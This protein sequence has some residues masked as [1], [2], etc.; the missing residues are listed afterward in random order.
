MGSDASYLYDPL[1]ITGTRAQQD[2]LQAQKD[3]NYLN[4]Q[5]M[6]RAEEKREQEFNKLNKKKPDISSLIAA[7]TAKPGATNLTGPG[8]V[9]RGSLTL[10]RNSLLGY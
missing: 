3:A 2:A 5:A 10:G 8:G 4:E 1:D 9:D 7:N 6:R